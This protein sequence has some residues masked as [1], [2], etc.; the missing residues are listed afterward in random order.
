MATSSSCRNSSHRLH[1]LLRDLRLALQR[2]HPDPMPADLLRTVSHRPRVDKATHSPGGRRCI[3]RASFLSETAKQ[4]QRFVRKG[5]TMCVGKLWSPALA[6]KSSRMGRAD[7]CC[8]LQQRLPAEPRCRGRGVVA[9]PSRVLLPSPWDLRGPGFPVELVGINAP[10][11]AFREESR[12][13]GR[14]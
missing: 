4:A 1:A 9:W 2:T 5:S 10:H 8:T 13:R 14:V 11:A 6:E 12:I 3:A 7:F